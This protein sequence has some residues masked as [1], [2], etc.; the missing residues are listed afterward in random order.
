M[1]TEFIILLQNPNKYNE[2][3][4]RIT[5]YDQIQN[6]L[7]QKPFTFPS[8]WFIFTPRGKEMWGCWWGW[9][10]WHWGLMWSG[11][12]PQIPHLVFMATRIESVSIF[13]WEAYL[14]NVS[15][16]RVKCGGRLDS[17]RGLEME[18]GPWKQNS[19][20]NPW[21]HIGFHSLYFDTKLQAPVNRMDA[22]KSMLSISMFM[23]QSHF[24]SGHW[25]KILCC[26]QFARKWLHWT[27]NNSQENKILCF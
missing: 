26:T 6:E 3:Y 18:G 12:A 20:Q 2:L 4:Y 13:F 11:D 17:L 14:G 27:Y 22:K 7:K 15:C 1:A 9:G 5:S 23:H 19:I 16:W 25:K 8:E 21:T 10:H 24:W